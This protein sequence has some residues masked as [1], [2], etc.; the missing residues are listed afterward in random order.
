MYSHAYVYIYIYI[1]THI[2]KHAGSFWTCFL[3]DGALQLSKCSHSLSTICK[4][5][6]NDMCYTYAHIGLTLSISKWSHS[7][8]TICV[9]LLHCMDDMQGAV[10]EAAFKWC[11][12][13][14]ACYTWR[15]PVCA[16]AREYI[17]VW[18]YTCIRRPRQLL[19]KQFPDHP[20]P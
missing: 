18:V 8:S 2:I 7:L 3:G 10:Y 1:Y 17:C 16:H 11:D 5:S 12:Y 4:V 14:P 20:N 13:I 15:E 9:T 19:Y 6:L